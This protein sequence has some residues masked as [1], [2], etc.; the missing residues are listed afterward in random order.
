[1]SL[2]HQIKA[3]TKKNWLLKTA[4]MLDSSIE[5]LLPILLNLLLIGGAALV[6]QKSESDSEE[7]RQEK[8]EA[9]FTDILLRASVPLLAGNCCRFILNQVSKERQSGL[10]RSLVLINTGSFAYG[11]S[12]LIIQ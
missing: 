1:M 6:G 8:L 3:L 2:A 5:H 9:Y 7:R 11:L 12:F 10:L 4:N